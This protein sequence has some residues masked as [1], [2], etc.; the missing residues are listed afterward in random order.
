MIM[1]KIKISAMDHCV[2]RT[3]AAARSLEPS[4]F[5]KRFN[6]RLDQAQF[7]VISRS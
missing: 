7:S 4:E 5:H 2:C 1:L 3:V 6:C